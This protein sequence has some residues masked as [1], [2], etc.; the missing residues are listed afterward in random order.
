MPGLLR[1]CLAAALL[2]PNLPITNNLAIPSQ[3]SLHPCGNLGLLS[4][5]QLGQL[6]AL[7]SGPDTDVDKAFAAEVMLN[8]FL[9]PSEAAVDSPEGEKMVSDLTTMLAAIKVPY[10]AQPLTTT[11]IQALIDAIL[12]HKNVKTQKQSIEAVLAGINRPASVMTTNVGVMQMEAEIDTKLTGLGITPP[13]AGAMTFEQLGKLE[14]AFSASDTTDADK[15][16]AAMLA[17]G[18]N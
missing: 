11:Q 8:E 12:H 6:T 18:L 16:S 14:G 5:D 2:S 7:S 15:K 13:A 9:H 17:L 4:T 1:F 10:P 3:P